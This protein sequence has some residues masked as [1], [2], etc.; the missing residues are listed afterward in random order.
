M[1]K[2]ATGPSGQQMR[3]TEAEIQLMRNTF[4]GNED[5]L[6]LLRK[7]LW[8]SFDWEAPVGQTKCGMW[9]GL[10]QLMQMTPQ[11]REVVILTQIRLN[12]AIEHSLMEIQYLAN[13]KEETAEEREAR[14]KKD[15]VK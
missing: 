8:P 11:D 14:E 3:F 9:V 15:S 10:D 12:N 4:G 13:S 1:S 5:L 6:I 7:V 2:F